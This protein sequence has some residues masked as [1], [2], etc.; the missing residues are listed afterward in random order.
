MKTTAKLWM[1][2]WVKSKKPDK[3]RILV[4]L[5]PGNLSPEVFLKGGDFVPG[6]R[7]PFVSPKRRRPAPGRCGA[8][9]DGETISVQADWDG[10][11]LRF[12]SH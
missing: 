9:C 11:G 5:N 8:R 4:L 2:T 1:E 7:G 10:A 12:S 6:Q 3:K